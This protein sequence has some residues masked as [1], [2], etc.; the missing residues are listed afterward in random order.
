MRACECQQTLPKAHTYKQRKLIDGVSI[1][2]KIAFSLS[3]TH[4]STYTAHFDSPCNQ[5]EDVFTARLCV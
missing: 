4:H 5:K 3:S 1:T 2:S